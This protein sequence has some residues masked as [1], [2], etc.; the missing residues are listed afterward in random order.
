MD[1]WIIRLVLAGIV[2]AALPWLLLI[3]WGRWFGWRHPGGLHVLSCTKELG[4][5]VEADDDFDANEDGPGFARE[6]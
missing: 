4:R 5:A 6:K 1:E 2:L 3:S